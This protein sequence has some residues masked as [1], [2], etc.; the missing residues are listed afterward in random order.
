MEEEV[1]DVF[2]IDELET[3]DSDLVLKLSQEAEKIEEGGSTEDKA[4]RKKEDLDNPSGTGGQ[5]V[6]SD[7]PQAGQS[8]GSEAAGEPTAPDGQPFLRY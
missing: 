2:D 3:V 7:I 1:G 4:G 8:S 6:S 5:A